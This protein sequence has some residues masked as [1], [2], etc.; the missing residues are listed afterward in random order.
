MKKITILIISFV[1]FGFSTTLADETQTGSNTAPV[2]VNDSAITLED[3]SVEI[4]LVLNDTDVDLDTLTLTW[5]LNFLNWSWVVNSAHTWVIF[6]PNH[7][8]F[9]TWSFDYIVSDWSLTDTWSVLITVNPV[10]DAPIAVDDNFSMFKN[11]SMLLNLLSNDSDVDSNNLKIIALSNILNWTWLINS[12]GTWVTFTPNTDFVWVI[13][14]TYTLNDWSLSD[15][16]NVK[17]TVKNPVI[18]DNDED[19]DD[20]NDNND[21]DNSVKNLQ[22]EFIKKFKDLQD[23]YKDLMWNS[24]YRNEYLMKKEQLRSEYLLKLKELNNNRKAQKEIKKEIKREEKE[25]KKQNNK[26]W[27]KYKFKWDVSLQ[28]YK[29]KHQAKYWNLITSLSQEKLKIVVWRIDSL[30]TQVNNN[31][32]YSSDVKQ[33]INTIL[34]ALRELIVDNIN[35]PSNIIDIDSLFE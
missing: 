22:K 24:M 1:L 32:S 11:T 27:F 34:L 7:N 35:D 2:A 3:T 12:A 20:D 25:I 17:I 23:E 30:I 5:V 14:F 29:L 8:F 18:D 19:E 6:T 28:E 33:T 15:T 31:T 4:N 10:N 21:D 13:S 16:W 9:W 26:N